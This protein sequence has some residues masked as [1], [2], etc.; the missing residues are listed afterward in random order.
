MISRSDGSALPNQLERDKGEKT[1]ALVP[2]LLDPAELR[3]GR[4]LPAGEIDD[5][6][7]GLVRGPD[8]EFV[9]TQQEA[10]ADLVAPVQRRGGQAEIDGHVGDPLGVVETPAECQS[11]R[12]GYERPGLSLVQLISHGEGDACEFE[13]AV[14]RMGPGEA[15]LRL[16]VERVELRRL[17]REGERALGSLRMRS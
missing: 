17:F 11:L 5:V 14:Q 9:F 2:C 8:A 10:G 1:L 7:L 13:I 3:Q 6:V 12:R 4:S 15:Q 16:G